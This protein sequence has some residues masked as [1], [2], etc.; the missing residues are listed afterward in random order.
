MSL[1]HSQITYLPRWRVSV[2]QNWTDA[3]ATATATFGGEYLTPET[4]TL[5]AAPG[6]S[7]AVFT[8][9]SGS[10]KWE[11]KSTFSDYDVLDLIGW[12][13]KVEVQTGGTEESPTY[14]ILFVGIFD[15][16]AREI[17]GDE[18]SAVANTTQRITAFGLEYLLDRLPISTAWVLNDGQTQLL[19]INAVPVFNELFSFGGVSPI[20]NRSASKGF[21]F[22]VKQ[23]YGFG[24]AGSVWTA[25][26]IAE[27]LVVNHQ[28]QSIYFELAGQATQLQNLVLPRLDLEGQSVWE[29]LNRLI[30]YRRGM[31]FEVRLVEDSGV[32]GGLKPTIYVYTLVESAVTVG[33]KTLAAN[34]QQVASY[35]ISGHEV[36]QAVQ[37][38]S[39]TSAYGTIKVLGER[40]RSMFTLSFADSTLRIGWTSTEETAYKAGGSGTAASDKDDFR[41]TDQYRRVYSHFLA[42]SNWQ[43]QAGNGAGGDK[44]NANPTINADGTCSPNFAP[45]SRLWGNAR[46]F[47]D[48]LLIKK[49][50]PY[51]AV[52]PE[53]LEPIALIKRAT[54]QWSHIEQL[55]DATLPSGHLRMLDNQLGVEV[56]FNPSHQLAKNHWSGAAASNVSS[57]P[58]DYSDL[59]VTLAV[60]TDERL[61]VIETTGVGSGR[62]K[63]IY[64]PDAHFW[65]INPGTVI[66]ATYNG[67]L[68]HNA[69]NANPTGTYPNGNIIRNDVDRLRQ[70]A[71]YAKAWY[72]RTRSAATF[73]VLGCPADITYTGSGAG[74]GFWRPGIL[75]ADLMNALRTFTLNTVVSEVSVDLRRGTTTV[76]THYAELDFVER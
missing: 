65:W 66:A 56:R 41:A 57:P 17:E 33:T 50:Q 64:V 54:S 3:W 2:R 59:I 75:L 68:R 28:P 19:E 34:G 24:S 39:G 58:L 40:V 35:D 15:F 38:K 48:R 11:D 52:T 46:T 76:N 62:L 63:V 71:A 44:F 25:Y 72:G 1:E 30:S 49:E 47:L 9:L 43:W 37:I 23:C 74:T 10:V 7:S 36:A 18:T 14:S 31:G 70:I 16:D 55:G 6:I 53:Y 21:N 42:P 12:F 20:G 61:K 13:V 67:L 8:W 69:T 29:A 26:D 5:A 32:S 22:S 73:T 60:E 51:S 27:Y 45:S 4:V